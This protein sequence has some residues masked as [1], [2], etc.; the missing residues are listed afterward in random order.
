MLPN[1]PVDRHWPAPL[2]GRIA[3]DADAEQVADAVAV[4]WEEIDA[5]LHPIIGQR[6]VAALYNRS[7]KLAS[8]ARPWIGADPPGALDAIDPA[9]LRATL[10]QRTAQEAGVGAGALFQAFH[11]LLASL[12]GSSLTER[13]LGSVW[14][15]PRG[16]SP[17]QDRSS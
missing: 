10:S 15:P 9:P 11:E 7:L 16:D 13:L 14:A 3:R 5:A 1:D 8:Q 12:I 17:P 6:G 4:L 2:A